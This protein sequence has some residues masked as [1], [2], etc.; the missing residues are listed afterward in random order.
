MTTISRNLRKF[1]ESNTPFGQKEMAL[2]LGVQQN[3]YC[4]WESG[5]SDVKSEYLPKLS[6]ILGVEIKD[7]F[8]QDSSKV[9]ITQHISENKDSSI[10]GLVF[11]LTDEKSVKEL[12]TV[13][14][15][16]LPNNNK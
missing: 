4:T 15:N 14:K 3:T 10:N 8:S 11:V 7:L 16:N 5:T 13:L 2:Q 12:V 1:R 6:E 9:E